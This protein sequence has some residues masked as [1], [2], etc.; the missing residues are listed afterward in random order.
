MLNGC[1][2]SG[3]LFDYI[4]EKGRLL[5]DEARRYFQQIIRCCSVLTWHHSSQNCLGG[6]DARLS[7]RK[8]SLHCALRHDSDCIC[9]S[10][11]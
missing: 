7:A 10:P 1:V 8:D 3:E 9:R 2:Q 4:V 11:R 6:Y 5:E